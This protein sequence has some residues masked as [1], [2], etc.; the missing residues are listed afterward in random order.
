MCDSFAADTGTFSA[1][2]ENEPILIAFRQLLLPVA[3]EGD[4]ERGKSEQSKRNCPDIELAA[5]HEV[6][7]PQG[8]AIGQD[9]RSPTPVLPRF[10]G[11]GAC[12]EAHRSKRERNEVTD[13]G[14]WGA[15]GFIA[16]SGEQ[17]Q[18]E[19]QGQEDQRLKAE[20]IDRPGATA[21][22]ELLADSHSTI[23]IAVMRS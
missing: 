7:N 5:G 3:E 6:G 20:Q 1:L 17:G 9:S 16:D 15:Q 13:Q 12:K 2:F 14:Q 10:I 4:E 8:Y 22:V 21:G 23:L 11:E 19:N 18:I